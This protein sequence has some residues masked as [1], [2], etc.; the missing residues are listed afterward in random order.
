M[1]RRILYNPAEFVEASTPFFDNMIGMINDQTE[2]IERNIQKRDEAEQMASEQ[3]FRFALQE[4][5][6]EG[7]KETQ[8]EQMEFQGEQ[9]DV[10]RAIGQYQFESEM[11]YK[12]DA[13]QAEMMGRQVRERQG[14]IKA[15]MERNEE[16][17]KEKDKLLNEMMDKVRKAGLYEADGPFSGKVGWNEEHGEY[18]V[19]DPYVSDKPVNFEEYMEHYRLFY[20]LA[21]FTGGTHIREWA[22]TKLYDAETGFSGSVAKDD[23][24]NVIENMP[25]DQLITSPLGEMED[26]EG[27]VYYGKDSFLK[28]IDNIKFSAS[29]ERAQASRDKLRAI[30]NN[31]SNNKLLYK[32]DDFAENVDQSTVSKDVSTARG[33]LTNRNLL[34]GSLFDESGEGLGVNREE[35][36]SYYPALM[37]LTEDQE[38]VNIAEA[39]NRLHNFKNDFVVNNDNKREEEYDQLRTAVNRL[40]GLAMETVENYGGDT[41]VVPKELQHLPPDF[42]ARMAKVN[43]D[44]FLKTNPDVRKLFHWGSDKEIESLSNVDA[45]VIRSTYMNAFEV[46]KTSDRN[47]SSSYIRFGIPNE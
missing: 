39:Y 16:E 9:N 4:Q 18:T 33:I 22:N 42:L 44:E 34:R 41:S 36:N 43:R 14:R 1:A 38:P 20:N 2:R 10:D 12:Y 15:A 30:L 47:K 17:A 46:Q 25:D 32:D 23:E 21:E 13:L 35:F 8:R 28:L 5:Q 29:E 7:Q 31:T 40:E 27:N 26:G 3:Q 11:A 19:E 45:D 6:I 37:P 24:G